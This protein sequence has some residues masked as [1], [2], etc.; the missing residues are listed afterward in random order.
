MRRGSYGREI[1][2]VTADGLAL[3]VDVLL[4]TG[5]TEWL[6]INDQDA[7]KSWVGVCW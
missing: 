5:A 3:P 4:D 7:R 6:V 2:L 1:E